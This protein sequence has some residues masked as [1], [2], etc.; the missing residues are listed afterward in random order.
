MVPSSAR[1][2]AT[3]ALVVGYGSDLRGD[4][5][6]GRLVAD[7][8]AARMLNGVAV[9]SM[10]QLTPELA[11]DI[12]GTTVVVFVDASV[13]D[14]TVTVRELDVAAPASSVVTHH[15]TPASILSMVP[16]VG[17]VP[18]RAYV[19]SIPA[20]NLDLGTNLSEATA[21]AVEEAVAVVVG[22]VTSAA[23]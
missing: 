1:C 13:A 20:A 14:D 16:S 11:L 12:A 22:M 10:P 6:A 4:D 21:R 2:V 7:S 18:E 9:R 23:P 5:A 8:V 15:S 3:D 19:V 17:Q